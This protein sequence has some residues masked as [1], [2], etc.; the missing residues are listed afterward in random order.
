LS[1]YFVPAQYVLSL[2]MHQ[3][4]WWSLSHCEGIPTGEDNTIPFNYELYVKR[5][6]KI[7][8]FPQSLKLVKG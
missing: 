1:A 3:G 5:K 2:D 8:D 7:T 6:E 4:G